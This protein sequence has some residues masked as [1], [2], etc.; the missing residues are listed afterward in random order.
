MRRD[1]LASLGFALLLVVGPDVDVS[2]T[3][4]ECTVTSLQTRAPKGT[5]VTAAVPVQPN[6]GAPAHCEVDG[7]VATA[8]NNVTFRLGLPSLWNDKFLFEGVGGFGGTAASLR[9]G[10]DRGY[11]AA[12]TDT[13]HRGGA[14]DAAW[15]ANS[16]A[17]KVD[18]AHRGTHVAVVAAKALTEAYYGRASRHAY[19]DG[20]SNGGRQAL[21]E[22]QRY[23]EDFDGIVAGDPSFGALGNLRRTLI[24]QTLLS[25]GEHVLP[26]GKVTLLS[27][28]VLESCD[29]ADGLKDGLITDPRACAFRPETLLCTGE[30]RPDCLTAGQVESVHAIYE[31]V[32]GPAGRM[33]P[34]FPQGHEE[35]RTGWPQW[36]TGST[37]PVR[38]ADGQLTFEGNAPL[39]FRFMDGYLRHL[40][41][42]DDNPEFDWRTFSFERH[43]TRLSPFLEDVSP[44]GTDLSALR[45]RGGKLLLYHGWADPALSAFS[46]VSYYEEVVEHAGGQ[47]NSDQFVALFMVPG[48]HHCQGNGPG[49]N[50]FDALGTLDGWVERG[51]APV[52]IVASH[53][54]SGVIDRTRPLCRYPYVARYVGSGSI[55]AAD[56]FQCEAP[57]SRGA[58]RPLAGASQE[59]APG[60]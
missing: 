43:G 20:C 10:M 12:S 22:A 29:A 28:A 21:M 46:T 30:D 18:Y 54:A 49:P 45:H 24:Y 35:G 4:A 27:R 25:S 11:A 7:T 31:S 33:L 19:F 16:P 2:A 23:P 51:V 56:N 47:K 36:I 50:T 8:G 9:P 13:G 52:R 40:A 17:K 6:D 26:A 48:M 14:T 44:T 32:P 37:E 38:R 39:G 58:T 59:R 42:P 60:R 55:D 53:I 57:A 15:A 34:G 41:F 1:N 3:A 5:T